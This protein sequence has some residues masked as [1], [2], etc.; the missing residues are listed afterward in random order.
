MR[1]ALH[2]IGASRTPVVTIDDVWGDTAPLIEIAA[3]LGTFPPATNSYPG[4][5]RTIGRGDEGAFAYVDALLERVAP[6]MCQAFSVA[7]FRISEASFSLITT[8]GADLAAPQRAPHFDCLESTRLALLHYLVPTAGTAF[9]R[10]RA[11]G[12]EQVT[13][14]TVAGYVDIAKAQ[15]AAAPA[16]YVGGSN[17]YYE[18]IGM[19]EGY[20]DRLAIYP[21]NILHSAVIAPDAALSDDPRAG[22]ITANI[23]VNCA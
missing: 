22:R 19:I 7:G 6:H 9:Y 14:A 18:Q 4:L 5:R 15:A 3:G 11:T 16:R 12:L 8:P 10:H 13:A 1:A 2:H 23:F 20:R 21:G 17:D